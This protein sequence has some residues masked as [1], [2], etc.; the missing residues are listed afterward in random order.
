MSEYIKKTYKKNYRI[1]TF[2]IND[3]ET[4]K[5]T[6]FYKI[7]TFSNYKV[8]DNKQIIDEA[9]NWFKK[10]ILNILKKIRNN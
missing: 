7:I 3:V 4:K 9:L 6:D 5:N 1:Y 2:L 10:I 8:G